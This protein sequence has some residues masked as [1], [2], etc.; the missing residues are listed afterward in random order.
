MPT[1]ALNIFQLDAGPVT[2]FAAQELQKYLQRM[3]G[4]EVQIQPRPVYDPSVRDG[5]WLGLADQL[6]APGPF[7]P[8]SDLDDWIRVEV[9]GGKG[10]ICGVNARSVLLAVYRFLNAAGCRWVRPGADG[11]MIPRR[12]LAGI[13][14]HLEEQPAYR[15]R[16]ICIEGADRLE[17]VLDLI[18]WSA[19]NGFSG[20]FMQFREGHT[21]FDRW[22]SHAGS[23]YKTPEGFSVEKARE[24]TGRIERELARRGMVYHAVGH[25]WTC[26]AFGIP[27]LGWEP[28]VEDWP[29]EVLASLAEVDGRRAMWQD[30]P[31]NTSLCFSNPTVRQR[32]VDC[33]AGY[34]QEHPHIRVLH[35]WLDD[36]FNNECECAECRLMRPSDFY[37][38]LLNELDQELTTRGLPHKIVFLSYADL[39][40]PPERERLANPDRF[41]FMFAPITRSYR[42]PLFPQ[43]PNYPQPPYYRNRL[44]F[45]NN[46]DEQFSLL[47]G[48]Q[49]VFQGDSF[50]Y[51][52]HL[53]QAGVYFNDPDPI[54]LA[55]LL[56]TDIGNLRRLD[57]G[58]L[59]SCQIQRIFFPTGLPMYVM[60][61]A[62]WN[63]RLSFEEI[64]DDYFQAA[65]GVDWQRCKE[66]LLSLS[67]LQDVVPLREK[68][69]PLD[70]QWPARLSEGEETIRGFLPV[71]EQ[72]LGLSEPCQARSWHYLKV[73][74]GLMLQYLPLLAARAR[75]DAQETAR[76]WDKFKQTLWQAEE[77]LQPVF[78]TWAY[79]HSYERIFDKTTSS[80]QVGE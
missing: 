31:L 3:T 44:V 22:Y 56:H 48:W 64:L 37:V 66:Y 71:I 12:D 8:T 43:D 21:F 55:R 59:V 68:D 77:D 25:G 54:F 26:E 63:D 80:E 42:R 14:V 17:N 32:V 41:I 13:D 70:P 10:R 65:F 16:A 1:P 52:Y 74:A 45:S 62:L 33:A 36:G 6:E 72:N 15:H 11:E 40:W 5:I 38:L 23:P 58:G 61:R 53:W 27:G 28:V 79:T 39:L 35:F 7:R 57:L 50:I 51:D 19:K 47:R 20:Y 46:N 18:D 76:L 60:G 73:H 69:L 29:Q 24:F 49:A 2:G 34:A 67:E 4:A 75:G 78:D 30:I 9:S